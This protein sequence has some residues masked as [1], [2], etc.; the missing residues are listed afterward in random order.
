MDFVL[1]R[2]LMD[3]GVPISDSNYFPLLALVLVLVLVLVGPLLPSV[4][5]GVLE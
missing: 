4:I 2:R 3:D 5:G 1:T